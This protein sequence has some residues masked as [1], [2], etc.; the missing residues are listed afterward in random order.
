MTV[1][2]GFRETDVAVIGGGNSALEAVDDMVKIA[3]HVYLVSLTPLTGD[4]ML[5]DKI[6]A[7]GNLTVVLEHEVVA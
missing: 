7:A 4:Q 3:D 2:T 5:I 6:Q 1:E